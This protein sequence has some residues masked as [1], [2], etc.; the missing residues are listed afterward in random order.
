MKRN[1]IIALSILISL[2][3]CYVNAQDYYWVGG[4]GNWSDASNHWATSSGGT[5]FYSSPPDTINNVFFDSNSFTS[6]NDTVYFDLAFNLCRG[7]TI[8]NC[9][10]NPSFAVSTGG[11]ILQLSGSMIL[12]STINWL[13]ANEILFMSKQSNTTIN[14][15]GLVIPCE[16]YLSNAGGSFVLT[17]DFVSD[18]S[19]WIL[20]GNFST[21]NFNINCFWLE[22]ESSDPVDFGTSTVSAQNIEF[23]SAFTTPVIQASS[24]TFIASS[25]FDVNDDYSNL[26]FNHLITPYISSSNCFYS[27]VE[28]SNTIH[29]DGDGNTFYKI[30]GTVVSHYFTY[31]LSYNHFVNISS[32]GG[33]QYGGNIII[34]T[35][36]ITQPGGEVVSYQPGTDT[37]FLNGS[38]TFTGY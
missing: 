31:P 24:A 38:I 2:C 19:L 33:L 28:D 37:I 9:V 17:E 35:L 20:S 22:D 32:P 1:K 30:D 10:N 27:L 21:A 7:F 16:V 25:A 34:D 12:Q 29:I 8:S 36:T 11:N 23:F 14:T 6:A 4:T 18:K 5:S 13:P 3:C 15:N 26:L